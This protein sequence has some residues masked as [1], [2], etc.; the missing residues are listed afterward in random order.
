LQVNAGSRSGGVEPPLMIHN[1]TVF[2][3]QVTHRF[4][5]SPDLIVAS[6]A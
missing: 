4:L 5:K 3:D 2:I 6:A 1:R